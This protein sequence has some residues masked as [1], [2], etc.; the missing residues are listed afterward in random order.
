MRCANE[1]RAAERKGGDLRQCD[2]CGDA[3]R[4]GDLLLARQVAEARLEDLHALARVLLADAVVALQSHHHLRQ[5]HPPLV[6]LLPELHIL[7]PLLLP[8]IGLTA[9][10]AGGDA[11]RTVPRSAGRRR[12]GPVSEDGAAG[13]DELVVAP[14]GEKGGDVLAHLRLAQAMEV[15]PR[16]HQTAVGSQGGSEGRGGGRG[17]RRGRAQRRRRGSGERRESRG[18]R[19]GRGGGGGGVGWSSGREQVARGSAR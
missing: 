9:P 7:P 13:E 12:R 19:G 2:G 14:L 16:R 1:R 10:L 3:H 6:P 11:A 8:S 4:S 5:H 17:R 18:A 15:E